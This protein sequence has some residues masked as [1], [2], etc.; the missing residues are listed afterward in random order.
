MDAEPESGTQTEE[1][2]SESL[3]R[4]GEGRTEFSTK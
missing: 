4:A 2:D 3:R 1:K